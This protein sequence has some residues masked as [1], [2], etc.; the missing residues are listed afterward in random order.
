MMRL[1]LSDIARITGGT[2]IGE[3]RE[4]FGVATDSRKVKPGQLFVALKGERMDGH[5]FVPDAFARGA[6]GALVERVVPGLEA[7]VVVE[8]TYEALKRM[9]RFWRENFKGQVVAVLGAV[10]K[11]TTKEMLLQVLR[12]FYSVAG[13]VKSFNNVVGV[14]LTVLNTTGKED[15][16]VLEL[17]TNRR[18]E[19]EDLASITLPEHVIYTKLGPEHLEGLG[20]THGAVEEEYSALKWASGF[21]LVPDDAPHFPD[22]PHYRY[23]FSEGAHF[24][25]EGLRLSEEGVSFTFEGYEFLI[26]YPHVGFADNAL[27]VA[28]F[29]KLF[30]VPLSDVSDILR[31]FKGQPMRMEKV[32]VGGMLIIND[33]YNSNPIS[34]EGLLRS[35]SLLYGGRRIVF[36]FGDM[37]ELGEESE[38]W[39]RWA[40]RKMCK[41]GISEVIGY[42]N[43]SRFTVEEAKACGVP[44]W[45]ASSHEEIVEY[46]QQKGAEVVIVKGSRGMEMERVVEGILQVYNNTLN[47]GRNV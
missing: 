16:W 28:S 22:K 40:G 33:A 27:A 34:V 6:S 44:G 45:L 2:L 43:F 42:G 36:V 23:G 39:H 18:G 13:P 14:A 31:G 24:R 25:G 46:L 32:R 11:T 29:A 8:D 9:V 19:I 1:R 10:G 15:V 17:G 7:G 35:V 4:F 47:R 30:G 26:P 12:N 41:H 3:D 21:V 37:L 20:S 5:T 38:Y